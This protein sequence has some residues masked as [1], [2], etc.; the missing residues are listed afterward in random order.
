MS[1]KR[2][3]AAG[4]VACSLT[5]GPGWEVEAREGRRHLQRPF[6]DI[7]AT[8]SVVLDRLSVK[9][10]GVDRPW[11]PRICIGCDPRG[12]SGD[13]PSYTRQR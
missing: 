1:D 13:R 2:M 11:D 7:D 10:L 12:G 6:G 5:L 9:A 4:I 8:S 3:L